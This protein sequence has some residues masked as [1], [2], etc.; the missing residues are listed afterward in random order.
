MILKFEEENDCSLDLKHSIN[1]IVVHCPKPQE[2]KI[3]H[4]FSLLLEKIRE[5]I[6]NEKKCIN[7]LG[8]TNL[9]MEKGGLIQDIFKEKYVDKCMLTN[10]DPEITK[11][12]LEE[13]F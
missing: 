12:D 7:Y 11:E 8:K 3:R 13:L 4:S 2:D 5:R 6:D 9:M 10:I 1:M